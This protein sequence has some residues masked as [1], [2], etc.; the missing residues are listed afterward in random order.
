MTKNWEPHAAARSSARS[1]HENLER[2]GMILSQ[3]RSRFSLLASARWACLAGAEAEHCRL[4]LDPGP[5]FK[6]QNGCSRP[7]ILIL[8]CP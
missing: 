7:E 1:R 8:L 6:S 5:N 2:A 3:T 4:S